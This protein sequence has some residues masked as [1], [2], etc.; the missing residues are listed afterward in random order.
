MYLIARYK[1]QLSSELTDKLAKIL[2]SG[3][4]YNFSKKE[5]EASLHFSSGK[6]SMLYDLDNNV[7]L[8]L[9]ARRGAMFLG[10]GNEEYCNALQNATLA[11]ISDYSIYDEEVCHWFRKYVPSC[12][13]IRFG[14]SGTEMVLNALR[15]SRAYTGR[16]R[17]IRF[18]GHCHGTADSIMGGK[19]KEALCPIV[20]EDEASKL[21]T[22][23]RASGVLQ[24]QMLLLPWNHIETFRKI[25]QA[26]GSDIAA[27]IMEPVMINGGSILPLPGYLNEVRNICDKHGIVLI[28]DEI[29][30]GVHMGLG[31]AQ[32]MTGVTPDLCLMGKAVSGGSVPVTALMGK[33]KIM[34]LYEHGSVVHGGTY[35]GYHLGMAAMAATFRILSRNEQEIYKRLSLVQE[36]LCKI[37]Q[38]EAAR[39]GLEIIVQG[40]S[41]CSSFHCTDKEIISYEDYSQYII[42]KDT[43]LCHCMECYGVLVCKASK[44]YLNITLNEKDIDFFKEHIRPAMEMAYNIIERLKMRENL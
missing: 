36:M 41:T 44:M 24:D 29:N 5:N 12:E 30:T 3:K 39:C 28:F 42:K 20:I 22:K 31:G 8:D 25:V 19:A 16:R 14:L 38:E 15:V 17:I 40:P 2:V 33:A 37:I 43:I 13:R 1:R 26:Y 23:G 35:N 34:D 4:H 32:V 21:A 18:N 27:V 9:Y 11:P 10:H 6:D 7:Y